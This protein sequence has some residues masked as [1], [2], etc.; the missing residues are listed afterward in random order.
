MIISTYPTWKTVLRPNS[1][2]IFTVVTDDNSALPAKSF[3][4]SVNTLD[5]VVIK[6]NSWKVYGIYCFSDCPSAAT[7]GTVYQ[8]LVSQTGGVAGDL[9]LQNFK[10]VF[11][12]LAAGIVGSAKLDC[13]WTIPPPPAGETFN[14]NKVNVI[15]TPGGGAPQ[16]PIG[17]VG[18]K[19]DCGPAGRL[20]LRRREQPDQRAALR[21]HLPVDPVG[22]Q[23]QDRHPVRL[24]YRPGA[25]L[26]R[27][28]RPW[29]RQAG[30]GPCLARCPRRA[31]R[32]ETSPWAR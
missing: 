14:K 7:P 8:E 24:R 11:D 2:K 22:S 9:C 10:P 19:A 29:T 31:P 23:R 13:A 17:K 4:D 26:I 20:V 3:T 12:K 32:R 1:L 16:P 15:F 5:P 6:P 27:S 30:M 28:G 21:R 18:S 25:A